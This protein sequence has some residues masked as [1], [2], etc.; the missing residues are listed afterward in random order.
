MLSSDLAR[1]EEFESSMYLGSDTG[2]GVH[3]AAAPYFIARVDCIRDIGR[4]GI[5]VSGEKKGRLAAR[6]WVGEEIES[7][8]LFQTPGLRGHS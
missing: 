2:F 3:S 6:A 4:D 8:L 1:S 5:D 7:L